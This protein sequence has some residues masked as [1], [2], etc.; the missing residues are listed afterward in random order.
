[1]AEGSSR[2]FLVPRSLLPEAQLGPER[3]VLEVIQAICTDKRQIARERL[4]NGARKY[5]AACIEGSTKEQTRRMRG[6]R[7]TPE[8]PS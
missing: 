1:M 6:G 5:H 3:G 7:V 4:S 2:L 8:T